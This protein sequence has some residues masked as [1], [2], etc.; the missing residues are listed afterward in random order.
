MLGMGVLG[1]R[2]VVGHGGGGSS[3]KVE[4]RGSSMFVEGGERAGC[5]TWRGRSDGMLARANCNLALEM[6]TWTAHVLTPLALNMHVR[7]RCSQ[8]LNSEGNHYCMSQTL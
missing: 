8:E 2:G 7:H 1:V 4:L 3:P 6:L 5:W